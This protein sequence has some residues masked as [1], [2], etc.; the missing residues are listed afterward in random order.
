MTHET[1]MQDSVPNMEQRGSRMSTTTTTRH[2]SP[3]ANNSTPDRITYTLY[4]IRHGE[5]AHNIL[6][7]S[8]KE[9]I[10][11]DA[12]AAGLDPSSDEIR[13]QVEE[14]RKKVLDDPTLFDARL[15]EQGR[16]EAQ[17]A[18]QRLQEMLQ[19]MPDMLQEPT[20]VLVSPLQ[21]ALQTADIIFP[22][23]AEVHIHVRE[24]LRER[25]TGKPPDTRSSSDVLRRRETF[26]RFSMSRLRL[27]SIAKLDLPYLGHLFGG[28]KQE[29]DNNQDDYL[30]EVDDDDDDIASFQ[31]EDK[32]ML[33]NR[34]QRLFN[35][36]PELQ[37]Q[38]IAV[39]THKGYLRE[40]EHGPLCQRNT[41]EFQ[42]CEIRVYKVTFSKGRCQDLDAI[43]RIV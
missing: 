7:K 5:A 28:V 31:E 20:E 25:Q 24:E 10:K 37:S 1:Y 11:E 32:H 41:P 42:N 19:T 40:L 16:I 6:E 18:R 8:A 17:A 29:D 3:D 21:R 2:A 27:F 39:V 36:L 43:E 22:P 34:T 23:C 13:A 4:L 12:V 38:H 26:Q 35:L 33:R 9:K 15:S 30:E 14:A